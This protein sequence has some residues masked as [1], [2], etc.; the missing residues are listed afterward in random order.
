[1]TGKEAT[2]M[3]GRDEKLRKGFVVPNAGHRETL[4]TRRRRESRRAEFAE[5]AL[6]VEMLQELLDPTFAFFSALENRARSAWSGLLQKRRGVRAGLPDLMI[7]VYWKPPVFIE[8]KS[9]R[10]VPSAAQKRIFAELRA[11]GADVYL[12]RSAAAAL[13]ALRR[14]NVP[15]RRPWEPPELQPWEGPFA[16]A[17]PNQR[18]PQ[19]PSVRAERRAAQRRWR[20]RQ[21]ARRAAMAA[22]MSETAAAETAGPR[23]AHAGARRG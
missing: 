11:I 5:Q 8:M 3:P 12:A 7:V 19:E 6:L 2:V 22:A 9:K 18:L 20:E 4:A 17:D 23:A 1:M 13:E 21:R 10:G 16:F 14:S 15:F